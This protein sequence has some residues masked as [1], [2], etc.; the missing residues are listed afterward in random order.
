MKE[1][2]TATPEEI[3]KAK[4]EKKP[5]LL[6]W[7]ATWCPPCNQLKAT[8]FNRQDFAEVAKNVVAAGLLVATLTGIASWAFGAPFLTSTYDYFSLP[9]IGKFE[10]ATAMLFDTGVFLTVFGAVML[11]LAQLSHIAQRAAR[12]YTARKDEEGGD[13]GGGAATAHEGL[14][15]GWALPFESTR[16]ALGKMTSALACRH[17][18]GCRHQ[19]TRRHARQATN[20]MAARAAG[21]VP[22]AKA[23][24]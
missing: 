9:L 23:D 3:A 4:A 7:G 13:E 11:A 20:A 21:T 14:L 8:F 18:G 17:E 22:C 1:N 16:A 24:Q 5:V 19:G 12:A 15:G 6:Y 2:P 10:L